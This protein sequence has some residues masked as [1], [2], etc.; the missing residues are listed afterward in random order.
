ME[1]IKKHLTNGQ[2]I[3]REYEKN[4]IFLHHTVGPTA[5]G[6][7]KWWNETPERVGTPYIID[8]NGVIIECFD[9]KY[10]AYH[11]GITGDDN[12]HEMHSINIELVSCGKLYKDGNLFKFYPLYP[13]TMYPKII[14]S[15]EVYEF[16]KSWK[17]HTLY[18]KYTD[19][20]IQAL[21]E[22]LKYILNLFPTIRI[23]FPLGKF[24][25]FDQ[26]VIDKHLT[27]LWSHSTVRA[28]K[29]DIYP[30]PP[31]LEVLE[32]LGTSSV[33]E[34]EIHKTIKKSNSNSNKTIKKSSSKSNKNKA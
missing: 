18:H 1:I 28:D 32:T 12:Y 13:N 10:W 7:W 23:N 2:Y 17:G 4:S 11:L 22:L 20:Q 16:K 5:E 27:G 30:Y 14:P 33:T 25:E 34:P 6:A 31:F 9:P 19:I 15:E 3:T 24:Y 29:D 21:Q 8:R 26:D